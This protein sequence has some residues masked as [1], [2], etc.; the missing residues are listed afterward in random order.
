MIMTAGDN[1]NSNLG[2]ELKGKMGAVT[3]EGGW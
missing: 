3:D 2:M 1:N